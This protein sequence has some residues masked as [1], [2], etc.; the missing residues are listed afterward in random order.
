MIV[1]AF[2]W[3]TDSHDYKVLLLIQT[4]VVYR[5]LE[6]V[7]IGLQP[8]WKIDGRAEGHRKMIRTRQRS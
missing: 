5:R 7:A 4:K 1:I 2:I 8:L 3:T 6:E